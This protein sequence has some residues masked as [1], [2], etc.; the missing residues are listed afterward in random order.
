MRFVSSEPGRTSGFSK[1]F[2]GS[3][4][5]RNALHGSK[6]QL[7]ARRKKVPSRLGLMDS[8]WPIPFCSHHLER[9]K[10][11]KTLKATASYS[12][13]Q[14]IYK[15]TAWAKYGQI[16]LSFKVSFLLNIFEN[17]DKSCTFFCQYL[18]SFP[19]LQLLMTFVDAFQQVLQGLKR[20]TICQALPHIATLNSPIRSQS[21]QKTNGKHQYIKRQN[22]LSILQTQKRTTSK[23]QSRV[24]SIPTLPFSALSP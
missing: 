13:L 3:A 22:S 5:Q 19:R 6:Q 7:A 18:V 4:T 12:S 11:W 24:I 8:G 17:D 23:L 16:M 9:H 2:L 10:S 20:P 21:W 1:T 14:N 15:M